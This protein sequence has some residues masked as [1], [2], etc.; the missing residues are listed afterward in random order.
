MFNYNYMSRIY[1]YIYLTI[2]QEYRYVDLY[3]YA[4]GLSHVLDKK[5]MRTNELMNFFYEMK[6]RIY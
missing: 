5:Y 3:V 1:I 6:Q 4:C 2:C